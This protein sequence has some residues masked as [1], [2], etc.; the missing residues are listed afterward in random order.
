MRRVS[1]LCRI[2]RT[3]GQSRGVFY[4]GQTIGNKWVTPRLAARYCSKPCETCLH[5][6]QIT[7][8]IVSCELVSKAELELGSPEKRESICLKAAMDAHSPRPEPKQSPDEV[9]GFHRN[10]RRINTRCIVR[11]Y[12]KMCRWQ[13]PYL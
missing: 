7:G 10:N 1:V 9:L 11:D 4:L 3:A 12:E 5:P 13:A 2:S 8:E 6:F